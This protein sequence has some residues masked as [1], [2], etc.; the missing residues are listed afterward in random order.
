MK[1]LSAIGNVLLFILFFFLI[2]AGIAFSSVLAVL[3]DPYFLWIPAIAVLPIYRSLRKRISGNLRTAFWSSY[4]TSILI[5]LFYWIFLGKTLE[6]GFDD[7]P[8]R[9]KEV[10]L[11]GASYK[12]TESVPFR[13]GEL[14]AYQGNFWEIPILAYKE[15]GKIVWAYLL[16]TDKKT[17]VH[18]FSNLSVEYG[19]LR[20]RLHFI[21]RWSHGAERG[22]AFIWKFGKLQY[23]YLSW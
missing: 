17:R 11:E 1:V 21:G 13:S 9:G 4:T 16:Y 14:V 23:F 22:T 12:A 8:F 19:I 6:A 7:G 15:N 2:L 5:L 10:T 18:H 20:D 3:A